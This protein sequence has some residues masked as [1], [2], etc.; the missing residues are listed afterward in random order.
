MTI[1]GSRGQA[2]MPPLADIE[3]LCIDWRVQMRTNMLGRKFLFAF[4]Y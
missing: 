1:K 3:F 4:S 2:E